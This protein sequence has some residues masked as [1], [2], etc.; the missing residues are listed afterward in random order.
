MKKEPKH[1]KK[2]RTRAGNRKCRR[3]KVVFYRNRGEEFAICPRCRVHC[4]RCD[5]KLTE[6]NI[7]KSAAKRSRYLCKSCTAETVRNTKGNAGFKQRDYDLLRKYGI[8]VNE[9]EAMLAAQYG[10]CWIC[11][12]PPKKVRLAVDHKHVLRDKRQ[13]PR[14]TR[15]RV[16][17]LLCWGCNAALAK[18]KDDPERLRKAAEYIDTLPAQEILTRG[19][20]E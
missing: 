11:K 19:A 14:D 5:T 2:G 4:K 3:C 12:E 15:T 6:E 20:K 9:Y 18:F 13:N 16:R 17:G 7:D 8:T 1:L 10:V